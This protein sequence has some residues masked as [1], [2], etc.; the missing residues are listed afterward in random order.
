MKKNGQLALQNYPDDWQHYDF[1]EMVFDHKHMSREEFKAEFIANMEAMYN[2]HI[3]KKKF[4][5]SLKQTKSTLAAIWA[6]GSNLQYQNMLYEG[7]RPTRMVEDVFGLNESNK[8]ILE[9]SPFKWNT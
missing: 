7:E 6:Y 5:R 4:L 9:A 8:H 1:A 3:I 2:D